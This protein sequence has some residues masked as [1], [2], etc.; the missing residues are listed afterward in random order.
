[1]YNNYLFTD[2]D[3]IIDYVRTAIRDYGKSIKELS[4][5]SGVNQYTIAK[6]LYGDTKRPQAASLNAV[7]RSCFYKLSVV[8]LSAPEVIHPTTYKP[9]SIDPS[10]VIKI[11]TA[12]LKAQAK[13]RASYTK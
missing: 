8:K 9:T 13:K 3:P 2:K 7:L 10:T 1:M 12:R 4:I 11:R 5:E 6:W